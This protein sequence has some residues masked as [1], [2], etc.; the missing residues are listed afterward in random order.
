MLGIDCSGELCSVA[1]TLGPDGPVYE[2][3][4]TRPGE[5]LTLLFPMALQ[6]LRQHGIAPQDLWRL[7]VAVGPGSFTG[8]R[9]AITTIRT[10]AQ[11]L[12]KPVVTLTTL[13]TIA[14]ALVEWGQR[15]PRRVAV[16][17]DARKGQIFTAAY[18]VALDADGQRA[19]LSPHGSPAALDPGAAAA[20][21]A[22]LG[23]ETGDLLVG[24]SA[25]GRF[26]ELL[27][28]ALGAAVLVPQEVAL[29]RARF[30]A[31]A[32]AG[33]FGA[34]SEQAYSTVAPFYL[35]PPDTKPPRRLPRPQAL[36]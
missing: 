17:T 9:L 32:A 1:V 2:A 13:E 35:R 21:L 7:G 28:P 3:E 33:A 31:R 5:Q 20:W 36:A 34:V 22:A 26:G 14:L 12:G 18:D 6:L 15:N 24:G 4:V 30:V 27:R 29:P 8:L 25:F 16:M 11:V 19:M 10:M 23:P